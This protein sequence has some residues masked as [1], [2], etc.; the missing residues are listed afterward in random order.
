M[1]IR[2]TCFEAIADPTRREIIGLIAKEPLNLNAILGIL[3]AG[4]GR[5]SLH[6]RKYWRMRFGGD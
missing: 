2:E 5:F 1:E 6:I 3:T 4:A